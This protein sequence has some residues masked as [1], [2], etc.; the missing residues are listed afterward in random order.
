MLSPSV[1]HSRKS[2]TSVVLEVLPDSSADRFVKIGFVYL[3]DVQ[4]VFVTTAD[5][6]FDHQFGQVRAVNE[7]DTRS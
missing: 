5:I 1:V 6:V 3:L 2:V 7:N 4:D